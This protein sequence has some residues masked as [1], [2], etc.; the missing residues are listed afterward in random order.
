MAARNLH[1][2]AQAGVRLFQV[3]LYLEDIWLAGR[4]TLDMAKARRQV[5]GV[6]DQC[7]DASV[8]KTS[9]VRKRR[10]C[11]GLA[12]LERGISKVGSPLQFRAPTSYSAPKNGYFQSSG[13]ANVS[14][15][16]LAL[17]HRIRFIFEP[18]LSLVPDARAPPNGC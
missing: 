6:L 18:A 12:A 11:I 10:D 3:D 7:P 14:L 17:T 8:V 13:E 15:I 1:N 2:F 5:R 16:V 4:D 9:Q